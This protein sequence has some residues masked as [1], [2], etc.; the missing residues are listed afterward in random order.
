MLRIINTSVDTTYIFSIDNH[1]LTVMSTDFV[2]I[3]PYNTS[4]I[5]VGIGKSFVGFTSAPLL[6]LS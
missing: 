3:E 6:I 1:N 5:V 2:P 4:H